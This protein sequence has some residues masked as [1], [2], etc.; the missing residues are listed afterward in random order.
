METKMNYWNGL[1]TQI[2]VINVSKKM[3]SVIFHVIFAYYVE[4]KNSFKSIYATETYGK[5][6]LHYKEYLGIIK[7]IFRPR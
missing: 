7:Y 1:C 2:W 5:L 6:S 3:N 4:M